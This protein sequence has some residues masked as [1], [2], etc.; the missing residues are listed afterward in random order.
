MPFQSP[1]SLLVVL[2]PSGREGLFELGTNPGPH[3]V[4]VILRQDLAA[5]ACSTNVGAE[6][7]AP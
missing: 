7:G 1:A 6:S 5:T 2:A 3:L 4:Q